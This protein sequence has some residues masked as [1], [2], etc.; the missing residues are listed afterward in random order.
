MVTG[1]ST[2]L[3]AKRL[4]WLPYVAGGVTIFILVSF[5]IYPIGKT[6]LSSW[7]P[8]KPRSLTD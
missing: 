3:G 7:A 8:L 2:A 5:L 4:D 6:M 1:Q